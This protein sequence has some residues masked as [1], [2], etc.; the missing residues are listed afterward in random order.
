MESKKIIALGKWTVTQV[1]ECESNCPVSKTVVEDL[2]G[3]IIG[4]FDDSISVEDARMIAQAPNMVE[5]LMRME[6][7]ISSMLY[8][9][10]LP[11]PSYLSSILYDA[12]L[13]IDSVN[14]RKMKRD[15]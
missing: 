5:M 15:T 3:R 6:S 8:H 2:S 10:A 7:A 11:S 12:R 13:V 4:K 1:V 14:G 9:D